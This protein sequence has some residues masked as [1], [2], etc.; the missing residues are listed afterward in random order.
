MITKV[1]L[2]GQTVEDVV[3]EWIDEQ[4]GPLEGLDRPIA[5]ASNSL[6]ALAAC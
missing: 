3:A 1:D 4:R 2:D 6:R 5:V